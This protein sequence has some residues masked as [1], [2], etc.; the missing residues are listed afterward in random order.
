MVLAKIVLSYTDDFDIN[1]NYLIFVFN[2][3]TDIIFQSGMIG[4][5]SWSVINRLN[6]YLNG[7]AKM[8]NWNSKA[9]FF[10]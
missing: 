6:F 8:V 2:L 5:Y 10:I 3:E 9:D 7:E 4:M 1:V